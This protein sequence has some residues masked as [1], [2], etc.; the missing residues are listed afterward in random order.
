MITQE[1]KTLKD[2]ISKIVDRDY[3]AAHTELHN[4]V[5]EKLKNLIKNTML[6]NKNNTELDK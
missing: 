2:F 3:K 6:S 1:T 5:E 4:V